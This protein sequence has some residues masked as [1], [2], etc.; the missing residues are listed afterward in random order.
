MDPPGDAEASLVV[1]ACEEPGKPASGGSS[2]FLLSGAAVTALVVGAEL[3]RPG[4]PSTSHSGRR[5][6]PKS[7]TVRCAVSRAQVCYAPTAITSRP[8]IAVKFAGLPVFDREVVADRGCRDHRVVLRAV[9]LRPAR[10]SEAATRP[11][12]RAAAASNGRR[13]EVGPCLLEVGWASRA[14]SRRRR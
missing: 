12:A 1:A 4:G 11:K 9:G 10:R 6:R 3:R 2:L 7:R 8:S 14:R 5:V 13:V